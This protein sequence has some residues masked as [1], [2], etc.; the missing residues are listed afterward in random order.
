MQKTYD[1]VNELF[2]IGDVNPVFT[3]IP[4]EIRQELVSLLAELMVNS[5]RTPKGAQERK[6]GV[7]E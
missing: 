1:S 4:N 3:R 5:L 7:H 6:E 2:P